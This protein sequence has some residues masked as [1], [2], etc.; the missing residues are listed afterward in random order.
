L[1]STI[2]K[3]VTPSCLARLNVPDQFG[4]TILHYA[5]SL[6]LNEIFDFLIDAGCDCGKKVKD[7]NISSLII[8]AI[9]GN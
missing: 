7:T 9:H 6:S 2:K 1:I 8:A 3:V 5:V 4:A